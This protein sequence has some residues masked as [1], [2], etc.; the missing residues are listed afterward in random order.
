M[1]NWTIKENEFNANS[2]IV[3]GN[4][5]LIGNG[6]M[7]IRGT[8]E[9]FSKDYLV[10]INLAGIYDKVGD[11][12]REPLNAPNA[13]K[14][15]VL[16]DDTEY[17]LPDVEPKKHCL[18]LNYRKA[19]LNRETVWTNRKGTVKVES[20]RF[21][22]LA[23]PHLLAMEY[24]ITVDY[25]AK[26][27]IN[28]SIDSDI[29]DINGPHYSKIELE[30]DK[31]RLSAKA[32]SQEAGDT[33]Y[34]VEESILRFD[35]SI[36]IK[37]VDKEIAKEYSFFAEP[38][39]VYRLVKYVAIFTSKDCEDYESKAHKL[40]DKCL[41]NKYEYVKD[42][43]IKEWEKVWSISEVQIVGDD[44]A[45]EALNY[46]LYHL[47]SIAPRHASSLS[48]SARGLS[49]QTYKGAVFWD[50]EIFM[51][52][53]F[54]NTDP[55]IAK[56]LIQY[57]IDTL[58]G[59]LKK[60]KTYGYDGAFYPWESQEGGYD[61]CSDYNVTDVFTQRPMRT[62]FKDKQ[63]HISSAIVYGI[64]K[65]VDRTGDVKVL[66]DGGARVILEC[67]KFYYSLL[68]KR[69][70]KEQYELLDVIGPDE[71]HERVNNNGYTN[72]MAKYTFDCC[73]YVLRNIDKSLL[74]GYLVEDLIVK[75]QDASKNILI[76][77]PDE[78]GIIQQFDGY[79]HLEDVSVNDLKGRLLNDKEYWGGAYGVAT[80][81]KIA[82][83]A[84][85]VAWLSFFPSDFDKDILKKNWEYY[86]KRAEHGSSLSASMF[87]RLACV[88]GMPQEAYPLFM[89]SAKE[90]IKGAGKQW[91]GLVYIGGTHPAAAGGAYINAVYGFAGLVNENNKLRASPKLPNSW[92]RL[93]FKVWHRKSL[94]QVDISYEHS[95]ITKVEL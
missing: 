5:F 27:T 88:C 82:K 79:M 64:M 51:L 81:T 62:Y 21:A 13:L 38:N 17:S 63:I 72:R 41:E 83:Q 84:D 70:N 44:A 14:T 40:I 8:L 12:W 66:D 34:V 89:K 75:F 15:T 1:I 16:V 53:F 20:Q 33:V 7:G 11:G 93:K 50:T 86:Q 67:G 78:N 73:I 30:S 28:T 36:Q 61:A 85:V 69:L 60:A 32:L 46:S 23:N 9:E 91:A 2:I 42:N 56:T 52:D 24:T 55:K 19:L 18:S 71:Y 26:I 94:Y 10:A 47:N 37:K 48:I 4:K 68:T 90:D 25:R 31:N 77:Q 49:G 45:M 29:W 65:Y 80:E 3:N 92:K 35:A 57:R 58:D 76:Q 22:S 54:I 95:D 59:A 87:A 6:Y 43:H 39:K 74:E